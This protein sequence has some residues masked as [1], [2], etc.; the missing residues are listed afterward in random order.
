M[1]NN[2]LALFLLLGL[3][4]CKPPE[5]VPYEK[6]LNG[7][8]NINEIAR[9]DIPATRLISSFDRTGANEDYNG[10]QGR[11]KDGQCILADLK[12]PGVVS[13]FWFTGIDA[14]KKIRFYFDGEKVPR[15]EFSWNELRKGV[16]PFDIA[17]LSAD[18][19]SCWYT[20]VPVPFRKHLLITTEDAGYQ[21][22][23]GPKMY[24]QLNWNPMPAGQTVSSFSSF[25]AFAQL[26]EVSRR[27]IGF[28]FGLLPPA[29]N[30][31]TLAAGQTVELW[32]GQGPATVNAFTIASDV[33]DPDVLRNVLLKIYW[34]GNPEPSVSVPLGDFFGSVW[35][36]WRAQ[37]MFFGSAGNTFFAAFRCRLRS[38]PVLFLKT[39]ALKPLR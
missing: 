29:D 25:T 22:G 28:D 8:T 6:P 20:F 19:Q 7:L 30:A 16:P 18:E 21:Y 9:L 33:C 4:A 17:P 39:K 34:D 27:W 35:Q 36:R 13:R 24:Y 15:L 23:R 14:E 3:T 38:R 37:S 1:K 11:A 31:F 26:L 2:W 32:S 12:G 5:T 10:F